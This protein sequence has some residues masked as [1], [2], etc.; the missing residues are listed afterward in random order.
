MKDRGRLVTVSM[1]TPYLTLGAAP[2][3]TVVCPEKE[4]PDRERILADAREGRV[5]P[6]RIELQPVAVY[7]RRGGE[8]IVKAFHL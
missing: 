4:L 1:N 7:L 2:P 6:R 5:A 8:T 3:G